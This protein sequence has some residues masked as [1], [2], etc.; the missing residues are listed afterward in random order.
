M[1]TSGYLTSADAGGLVQEALCKVVDVRKSIS[2][3]NLESEILE[4]LNKA[5][6]KLNDFSDEVEL[7]RFDNMD[8]SEADVYR[9]VFGALVTLAP[10]PRSAIETIESVFGEMSK[11]EQGGSD[12]S[13]NPIAGHQSPVRMAQD[14][15]EAL[16]PK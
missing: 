5:E 15:T 4:R 14:V 12:M 16:T 3:D 13:P 9:K 11:M 1:A 8:C 6:G 7:Q 2:S 10:S